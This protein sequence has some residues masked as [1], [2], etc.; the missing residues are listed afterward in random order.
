ME[1]MGDDNM[2]ECM[3]SLVLVV[4]WFGIVLGMDFLMVDMWNGMVILWCINGCYCLVL[5]LESCWGNFGNY[6]SV[7]SKVRCG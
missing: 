6:G 7:W 3:S 5:Y 4:V 2:D 1:W